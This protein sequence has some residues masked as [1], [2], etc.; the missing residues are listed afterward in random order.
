MRTRPASSTISALMIPGSHFSPSMFAVPR[1]SAFRPSV[2]QFGQTD[3]IVRGIPNGITDRSGRLDSH[4]GAHRAERSR[5]GKKAL[6][7]RVRCQTKSDNAQTA[8]SAV[9]NDRVLEFRCMT[10]SAG[11]TQVVCCSLRF[12]SAAGALVDSIGGNPGVLGVPPSLGLLTIVCQRK[13]WAGIV[14]SCDLPCHRN[15]SNC[16]PANE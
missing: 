8:V 4:P 12:R 11:R 15:Q 9:R 14:P 2:T 5:F 10:F 13:N 6:P 3:C 1:R 16:F 7:T